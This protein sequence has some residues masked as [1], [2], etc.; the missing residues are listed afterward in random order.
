MKMSEFSWGTFCQT[1]DIQAYL[2]YKDTSGVE[3][4]KSENDRDNTTAN[5]LWGNEQNANDFHD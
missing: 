3:Y 1:G 2:L 4:G 5:G